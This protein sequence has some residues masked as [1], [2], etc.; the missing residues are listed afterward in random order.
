LSKT[1][2]QLTEWDKLLHFDAG[3]WD[4]LQRLTCMGAPNGLLENGGG[5]V[6][7]TWRGANLL[8]GKDAERGLVGKV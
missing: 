2:S 8:S 7:D 3:E 6:N 5:G 4:K 1:L